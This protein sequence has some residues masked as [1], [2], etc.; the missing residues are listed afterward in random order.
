MYV[1]TAKA[2]RVLAQVGRTFTKSNRRTVAMPAAKMMRDD[3]RKGAGGIVP[4]YKKGKYHY[5]ADKKYGTRY[6]IK[7][8]NLKKS[9]RI[10][11][12]DNSG[13]KWVGASYGA[14]GKVLIV[15]QSYRSADGFYDKWYIKNTGNHFVRR[16]A[17]R[18][19]GEIKRLLIS[20]GQKWIKKIIAKAHATP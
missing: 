15:G 1:D 16:A 13:L 8:G 9:I 2:R 12:W 4:E 11:P 7:A 18:K 19:K 6:K 20:E 5:F 3:M 14:A 10:F 17:A